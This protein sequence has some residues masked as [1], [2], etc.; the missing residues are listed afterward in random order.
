MAYENFA[1]TCISTK[2]WMT[3]IGQPEHIPMAQTCE[4]YCAAYINYSPLACK[5]MM[6]S[7]IKFLFRRVGLLCEASAAVASCFVT[8]S[9]CAGG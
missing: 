8:Y 6:L 2:Q 3:N 5:N 1:K 4:I 7:K 9:A